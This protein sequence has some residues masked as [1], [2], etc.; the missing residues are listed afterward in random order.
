MP[1]V[2]RVHDIK[3]SFAGVQALD[4]VSLAIQA[5]EVHCLAGENGS[6]KSTLIKI[7]AGALRPDAGSIVL[8]GRTHGR[9]TPIEAIR[10]GVQIIYQDFSLFDNL[11]VAENLVINQQLA[12]RQALVDWRDVRATA[13]RALDLIG[14]DIPLSA[15]LDTLPVVD[16]QLIAIARALIND[17]R[18]L[19]LD[20][21]TSA[22]TQQEVEKLLGIIRRLQAAGVAILFVSHKFN[23]LFAVA[24]DATFTVL[25]N[26]RVVASGPR[27]A[28]TYASLAHAMVG[29][30]VSEAA[31]RSKPASETVALRV[32]GLTK[33]GHFD[34]VDFEV[35]KG[36]ILGI[37][38][39][40][41]SGRTALAMSLFGLTPY[42]AGAV[43]I[44]GEIVRIRSPRDAIRANVAYVP[45][46]R[47][48]EGLFL[49][50]SIGSNV[51]ASVIRR[52][53]DRFGV[54]APRRVDDAQRRW[55][56][57][58]RIATPSPD[59]PVQSLSGGN[60]QRVVLARWLATR[61]DILILNGPTVG[62]DVGS[63]A[64]IHELIRSLARDGLSVLVI[65]DD[66]TEIVQTCDRVLV[67]KRGRITDRLVNEGLDENDLA[68][69]LVA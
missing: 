18:L 69:R 68:R 55:V 34:G 24:E 44:D 30:D 12:R 52:L 11:T 53:A 14:V 49:P 23:E 42:D 39:V 47:L 40:L 48:R 26:G 10:E 17:A 8:N 61:P 35:G 56:E 28:F 41:G 59:L 51:V 64:A 20:E 66:L 1:E 6:G 31:R 45:E 32:A 29:R 60:Q 25:R 36:E 22:L 4:D 54:L 62:V 58:L 43:S 38:G 67:M 3:K 27:D 63:K 19:I 2:L 37:T 7:V 46:D 13:R 57:E 9:V 33:A 65:S 50:R 16:R 5:G 15:R 21:P